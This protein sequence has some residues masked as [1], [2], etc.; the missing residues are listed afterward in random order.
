MVGFSDV[1]GVRGLGLALL[2]L[3]LGVSLS[4][5]TF[6]G[7]ETNGLFGESKRARFVA[8]RVRG[9]EGGDVA[10]GVTTA[11][12]LCDGGG[13]T[14]ATSICACACKRR[15]RSGALDDVSFFVDELEATPVLKSPSQNASSF[16]S[17]AFVS[18]ILRFLFNAPLDSPSLSSSSLLNTTFSSLSLSQ[19]PLDLPLACLRCVLGG[20]GNDAVDADRFRGLGI[21]GNATG[22]ESS[23]ARGFFR[24][25][26][27]V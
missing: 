12:F 6:W 1:F 5:T 8:E 23:I 16:A 24:G 21:E 27:F 3:G 19:D 20:V 18:P 15:Y 10:C 17:A 25:W 11:T 14:G 2:A 7:V 13:E 4:S 22:D 26:V 9:V